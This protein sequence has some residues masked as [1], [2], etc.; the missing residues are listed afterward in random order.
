MRSETAAGAMAGAL[1]GLVAVAVV[2]CQG[3]QGPKSPSLPDSVDTDGDGVVDN[4]ET[5]DTVT[6]DETG[7]RPAH[8]VQ[9]VFPSWHWEDAEG[10]VISSQTISSIA[11]L[12]VDPEG[13]AWV[14]DAWN[15][16]VISPGTIS[17]VYFEA[18][19]CAGQ[20]W[21][22]GRILPD[23]AWRLDP[24][25]AASLSIE[26]EFVAFKIADFVHKDDVQVR[27]SINN[28]GSCVD[29]T[30]TLGNSALSWSGRTEIAKSP[31]D[32]LGLVPPFTIVKD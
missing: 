7:A 8:H 11:P 17:R 2:N 20:G 13:V 15:G 10:T 32:D 5:G 28:L 18:S 31:E 19:G 30:E 9:G 26:A 1:A 23:R 6:D 4:V 3:G 12:Y 16:F 27:S 22:E 25:V 29:R 21:V 14:F 24:E